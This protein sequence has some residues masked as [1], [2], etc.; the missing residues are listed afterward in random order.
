MDYIAHHGIK[1]QRWGIR[2]YQNPDGTLTDAGRRRQAKEY[3]TTLRKA[4][5]DLQ[6]TTMA[7]SN[8]RLNAETYSKK[9][10]RAQLKADRASNSDKRRA[11]VLNK[12]NK[13]KQ[14]AD[15]RLEQDAILRKY[16]DKK[17][18]EIES[19]LSKLTS[20]G[21]DFK[22]T[23]TNFNQIPGPNSYRRTTS[24]IKAN[25]QKPLREVVIGGQANA[26]SG[27]YFVVRDKSKMSERKKERWA[28]RKDLNS[29]RPQQV[30]Y[31]TY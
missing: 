26:S 14:K 13:I 9:A 24:F 21:Y 17:I 1:G 30:R 20:E 23:R 18:S 10:E 6:F 22:V 25:G 15:I 12:A 3:Q 5:R 8:L 28:T 16:Q 29:Y 31:S 19:T 11:R 2:R 7:R 27:N 4:D